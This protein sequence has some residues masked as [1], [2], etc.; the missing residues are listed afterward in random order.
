MA[1][2]QGI[3]DTQAQRAALLLAAG[4]TARIA[5]SG[6]TA[7]RL[8]SYRLAA[9][10]LTSYRLAAGGLGA[11]S[12]LAGGLA[13]RI[14]AVRGAGLLASEEALQATEQVALL[15]AAR[16]TA[17]VAAGGLA[18]G[19]LTSHR[20]AASRL[21]SHR[22]AASGLGAASRFACGLAAGRLATALASTIQPQHVVQKLESEPLAS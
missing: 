3:E 21:T 17:R 5:A 15:A 6:L 2:E 11:A 20:L 13:A 22:L 19:G 18:A 8:T 14:A 7:S 12:R 9:G 1:T 16:I 10:G 4:I